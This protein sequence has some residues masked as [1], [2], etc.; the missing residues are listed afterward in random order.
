MFLKVLP[1]KGVIRFGKKG[2]LIPRYVGP[3]QIIFRIGQVAYK[4]ELPH[5]LEVV[6]PAFHISMLR[7]CLGDPSIITPIED[8]QV[9]EHLSYEEVPIAIVDR[10]VHKL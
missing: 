2:K 5:D 7:K 9:T 6:H 3:C 4:L 1:M 8:V 10:Q